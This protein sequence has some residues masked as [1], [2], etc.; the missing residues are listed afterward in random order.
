MK[1]TTLA[2]SLGIAVLC[3][4]VAEATLSIVKND[5]LSVNWFFHNTSTKYA[6]SS[7]FGY[8]RDYN[9]DGLPDY[10]ILLEDFRNDDWRLFT[11]N[12]APTGGEK[13]SPKDGTAGRDIAHQFNVFVPRTLHTPVSPSM[14]SADLV[15]LG[16]NA[17]T[18][19][20][21]TQYFTKYIFW[22][23]NKTN[24]TLPTE[25]TWS[26]DVVSTY[27][28]IVYWPNVSFD[29]DD[30]PDYLLYNM[31]PDAKRQFVISCYNG[32][33][34]GR[35][36]TRLL[37][38]DPQDPG[39]GI[40]MVGQG[41]ATPLN[42]G[43]P[44]LAVAVLP[45]HPEDGMVGDFDGNGKPE[46]F[47]L[48]TFGDGSFFT[49]YSMTTDINML[50]SSGNFLSPYTNT[51]T[52]VSRNPGSLNS[53]AFTIT[54][55]Y[56][57][58]G[59][60]DAMFFNEGGGAS[61][62]LFQAY[63][64]RARRLLFQALNSD[65]GTGFEDV[66]GYFALDER[67]YFGNRPADVNG[68]G[69]SDLL[70]YRAMGRSA[71]MPLRIGMFNGYASGGLQKGRRM[72]L[73]Q[74][75]NFN[76][77]YGLVND[78]NGDNLLDYVLL[79]N[80]LQPSSP[81]LGQ[82]TWRIANT[83][84]SATRIALGK[85][86]TYSPTFS[87]A[88]NP[89]SNAF[90]AY[91]GVF[92][93][94][95]D[96]DGDGQRDT[97]GCLSCEF[98]ANQDEIIDLA[99][100]YAFVYDNTAGIAPPPLTAEL[101]LRVQN[102]N[103]VPSPMLFYATALTSGYPFVD[104]NRDGYLND[105]VVR[106]NQALYSMSFPF[107][108]TGGPPKL[109]AATLADLDNNGADAGDLLILSLDRGVKVTT[110]VLRAS[111]FFLPVTGDSLGGR[112]F[113]VS[114]NPQNSR[115]VVL[116]LG[117]GPKLTPQGQFSMLRRISGSPSGIDFATSL[118]VGSI[119]SYDGITAVNGG[120]PGTND[121]GIDI[122]FNLV[123]RSGPLG[124]LGG[125]L[126]VVNSAD[127]AYQDHQLFVPANVL[128]TTTSFSLLRPPLNLGAPGA[129]QVLSS[130]SG[131]TFKTS[132]TLTLEYHEDD[133]DW[134]AGYIEGEMHVHQLV[135]NPRGVFNYVPVRGHTILMGASPR[136][137]SAMRKLDGEPGQVSVDLNNLNPNG[138]LGSPGLFAGLPIETVDERTM[139]IKPGSG[140]SGI[141]KGAG[142]ALLSPGSR[143]AYTL[144]Q[145]EFPG[146][147]ATLAT[148][149]QRIVIT[150]R[151]AMLAERYS[152]TSGRS[153]PNQSGAV[154]V[155][156]VADAVGQPVAFTS[157]VNLT[158]QFKERP[159]LEFTDA[160]TFDEKRALAMN[161]RLVRD[162]LAGGDVD[163]VFDPTPSQTVNT[164]VGTLT[165]IGYAGLT[166]ADGMGTFGAVAPATGTP[167]AGWRSYR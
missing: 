112:G 27:T 21:Q 58:D 111:H 13:F 105:V 155:V 45:H 103:W 11:L 117:A 163:F 156:T 32:R 130:P 158:V 106:A 16:T 167:V 71:N 75:N 76:T 88:F 157:P 80:P 159:E 4:Q 18:T 125:T 92:A 149:P 81:T 36:W 138:S 20:S 153:F 98:D 54:T 74:F 52:R 82:V 64:L 160:I 7:F 9:N 62:P 135:E 30:Y 56:N 86:F 57:R 59:F 145:I 164:I 129:V 139:N 63:D 51:W 14:D 113:A 134:D 68:D 120:V 79:N 15:V 137:G 146:Y 78:F 48:Y 35:I 115:Q 19:D 108:I 162:R 67:G 66:F 77:A 124:R 133:I 70:V 33:T 131:I 1:R 55:D 141:V 94:M 31:Y 100:G 53:P 132:A 123:G 107:K 151:T 127:A 6:G 47:L 116:T 148:D 102:E 12:T 136:G 96:V 110:S 65:F 90:Y 118:P 43:Y 25:A 44:Q 26:V 89:T 73:Q 121:S 140:S 104:N 84:V 83:A 41:D 24:R 37:G 128:A 60:E 22:R 40:G 28:P 91:P 42:P 143:G 147:V 5:N 39:T 17:N 93:R 95:G 150:I 69:W 152:P 38:P 29:A 97:L 109:E 161:M 101:I 61:L 85:Q 165:V 8:Y 119:R 87:F 144:H 114:V 23:L 99:Y 142:P 166:G 122:L 2:L 72:W 50:N 126:S 46:I 49:S 3:G 34:G 10:L 154:L